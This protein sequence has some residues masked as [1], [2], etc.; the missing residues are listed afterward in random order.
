MQERAL[1]GPADPFGRPY[2]RER[3][4]G[5]TFLPFQIPRASRSPSVS[6]LTTRPHPPARGLQGLLSS[7]R[8]L[9][10]VS[11]TGYF[12]SPSLLGISLEVW[13]LF[14]KFQSDKSKGRGE[15]TGI[16]LS[17]SSLSQFASPRPGY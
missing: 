1:Q 17:L 14:P 12:C 3:L 9:G 16:S 13:C 10:G 11:F 6:F 15:I 4:A 8:P 5:R 2:A 7:P